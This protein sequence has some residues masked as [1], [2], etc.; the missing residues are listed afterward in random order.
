MSCAARVVVRKMRARR[1]AGWG[2]FGCMV[3]LRTAGCGALADLGEDVDDRTLGGAGPGDSRFP[4]P[5]PDQA[6]SGWG[7]RD[8]VAGLRRAVVLRRMPTHQNRC[9]GHPAPA[10]R[11]CVGYWVRWV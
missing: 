6:G 9:M 5:S 10:L 3:D 4:H 11:S 8:F 2:R 1:I 7:T